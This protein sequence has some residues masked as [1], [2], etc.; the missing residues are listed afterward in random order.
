MVIPDYDDRNLVNVLRTLTSTVDAL[1]DLRVAVS[2]AEGIV[3]V[4]LD[5]LGDEQ[6]VERSDLAPTLAASRL[7]P[8]TSV[9]PSTTAV[10]LTSLLT[11]VPPGQHGV[12]GYRMAFGPDILQVLGWKVAGSDASALLPPRHVQPIEPIVPGVRYVGKSLFESSAFSEAHLRGLNYVGVDDVDHMVVAVTDAAQRGPLTL[13]YHDAID[14]VAHASGLGNAYEDEVRRA[15]SLVAALRHSLPSDVRIV[16]TSDHG[17]VDVGDQRIELPVGVVPRINRMTGEGRF[18]WLHVAGDPAPLVAA[19]GTALKES[20]WVLGVDEVV[21]RGL[22]GPVAPGIIER[23]GDV[24]IIPF[25]AGYVRDPTERN[26]HRM[27]SRHGSL[28]S[29]EMLVPLCVV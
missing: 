13:C 26:E 7:Q 17:Q 4:I 18:R 8:I 24:A 11:G 6:L 5:G 28:T 2:S 10:A 3:V 22:L 16:V 1:N 29:A 12:V 25:V 19:L 9:A 21:D 15:D 14:K 27:R 23:L 20:C